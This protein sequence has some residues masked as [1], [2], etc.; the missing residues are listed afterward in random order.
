MYTFGWLDLFH[1]VIV[2]YLAWI[3]SDHYLL[4]CNIEGENFSGLKPFQFERM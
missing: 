3:A 4:L 2:W 1:D